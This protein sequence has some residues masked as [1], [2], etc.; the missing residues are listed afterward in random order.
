VLCFQQIV[1]IDSSCTAYQ[2]KW[3]T[4]RGTQKQPLTWEN[5]ARPKDGQEKRR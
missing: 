4:V 2:K 5:A 1:F 3:Y